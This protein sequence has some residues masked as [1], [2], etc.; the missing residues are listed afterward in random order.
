M[1]IYFCF[2]E[3]VGF[4]N[5]SAIVKSMLMNFRD[6]IDLDKKSMEVVCNE[7]SIPLLIYEEKLPLQLSPVVEAY[8]NPQAYGNKRQLHPFTDKDMPKNSHTNKK[9]KKKEGLLLY[10]GALSLIARNTRKRGSHA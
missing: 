8:F 9:K 5:C 4:N 10:S 1:S 6:F 7:V 3:L 2:L